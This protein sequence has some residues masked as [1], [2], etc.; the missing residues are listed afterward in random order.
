MR[1]PGR[2]SS[3]R[4]TGGCKSTERA[5]DSASLARPP[6]G[7]VAFLSSRTAV[8]QIGQPDE[9]HRRHAQS[10]IHELPATLRW[11]AREPY[12]AQALFFALLLDGNEG[13]RRRQLAHL[14][15]HLEAGKRYFTSGHSSAAGRRVATS[16][17]V[18]AG[19]ALPFAW[20]RSLARRV[21]S[22]SLAKLHRGSI[23][24]EPRR[25]LMAM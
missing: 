22:S 16:S 6:L 20:A 13:I 9:T 18:M 14:E 24:P 10:L 19:C 12:G 21:S 15:T 7:W 2:P 17:R 1:A 5:A 11:A 4:S 23:F 8:D 25:A 3:L